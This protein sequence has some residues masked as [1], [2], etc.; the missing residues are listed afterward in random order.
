VLDRDPTCGTLIYVETRNITFNLPADLVRQ[1]KVYAE[2]HDT[3]INA[4]VRELLQEAL[5][6]TGRARAAADRLLALA[7][8]GPYLTTDPAS[9]RREELYDRR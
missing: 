2:E 9:I 7:D 3:T 8:R 1:A 6:R 4:L 5:T